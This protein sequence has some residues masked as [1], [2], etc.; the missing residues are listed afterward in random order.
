MEP[1]LLRERMERFIGTNRKMGINAENNIPQEALS[2]S[3]ILSAL[4]MPLPSA[5]RLGGYKFWAGRMYPLP[6]VS[7]A[8]LQVLQILWAIPHNS[9]FSKSRYLLLF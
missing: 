2:T 3:T 5:S 1:G 7:D 9:P 6:E 8:R 4:T